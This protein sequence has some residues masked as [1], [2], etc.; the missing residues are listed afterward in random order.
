[1]SGVEGGRG[2]FKRATGTSQMVQGL[3]PHSQC[4][5]HGELAGE[6]RPHMLHSAAKRKTVGATRKI[7]VGIK[8]FCTPTNSHVTKFPKNYMH[9][10]IH[11]G[12]D[13]KC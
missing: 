10:N 1:M 7:L 12:I 6:L 5:R 8:L 3:T 13:L 4:R 9:T 11:M 2:G